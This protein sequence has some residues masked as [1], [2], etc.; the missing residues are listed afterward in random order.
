MEACPLST[1]LQLQCHSHYTV[2]VPWSDHIASGILFQ[3][4]RAGIEAV[5]RNTLVVSP[6]RNSRQ[7]MSTS[8][9]FYFAMFD[10]RVHSTLGKLSPCM[11]YGEMLHAGKGVAFTPFFYRI[12]DAMAFALSL[13][14]RALG[15][16]VLAKSPS[17]TDKPKSKV[18]QR[19]GQQQGLFEAEEELTIYT[20]KISLD[21]ESL[22]VLEADG[23]L[24]KDQGHFWPMVRLLKELK[25]PQTSFPIS[26]QVRGLF[27]FKAS[28]VKIVVEGA[29]YGMSQPKH[30]HSVFVP[31]LEAQFEQDVHF[32]KENLEKNEKDI[33]V[34]LKDYKTLV[35]EKQ[36]QIENLRE[37]SSDLKRKLSDTLFDRSSGDTCKMPDPDPCE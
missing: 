33:E 1:Q 4:L 21:I 37:R 17:C 10:D 16:R 6:H 25:L 3:L 23:Y 12:A 30:L 7:G 31:N 20:Y 18:I 34:L 24:S 35:E 19:D 14:R 2:S 26:K 36:A 13:R 11:G 22:Q 27:K 28:D 5:S 32:W 9:Q 15:P 29:A 8:Y